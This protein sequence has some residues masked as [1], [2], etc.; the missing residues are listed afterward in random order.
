MKKIFELQPFINLDLNELEPAKE[1]NA[2]LF[3]VSSL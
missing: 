1:A 3:A 2:R